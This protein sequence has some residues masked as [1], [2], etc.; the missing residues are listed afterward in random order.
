MEGLLFGTIVECKGLGFTWVVSK[1]QRNSGFKA[2]LLVGSKIKTK[3]ELQVQSMKK[4]Q[5]F[6][7]YKLSDSK[8]IEKKTLQNNLTNPYKFVATKILFD[9]IYI[10]FYSPVHS[11]P[12]SHIYSI[13][14]WR[15]LCN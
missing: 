2:I 15:S 11:N 9:Q 8:N 1:D 12:P 7:Q 3:E 10:N 6:P 14:L 5:T 13:F 4:A